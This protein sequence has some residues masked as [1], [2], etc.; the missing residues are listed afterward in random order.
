LYIYL[1]LN[2]VALVVLE[3]Q[4][5]VG[6]ERL[7]VRLHLAVPVAPVGLVV[8]VV[9]EHLVVQ[10]LLVGLVVLVVLVVLEHLVAQWDL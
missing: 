2:L 10:L 7:A 1:Q 5:L 8:L 4:P 9:L 3:H 6:L